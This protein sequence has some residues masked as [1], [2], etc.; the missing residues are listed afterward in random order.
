M[1]D[2][3]KNA[4]TSPPVLDYPRGS[5]KFI[6]TTDASDIGLGAILSTTRGTVIEYASRTLN[7]AERNYTTTEKECLAIVWVIRKLRHNLIGARFTLETDHKP[8]EWLES[9]RTSRA[10]SQRL[11]RWALE[12]RAYD[13]DVVHKPGKSNL[14][15][16]ALSRNPLSMV[17][18]R[19]PM[20]TS[21]IAR[22]QR[23]DPVLSTVRKQLENTNHQ[24][25]MSG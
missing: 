19:P 5:D 2:Q 3:L 7:A 15:A 1:F 21:D 16:D 23:D 12:L 10:H 6:L 18:L 11:E 24:A 20:E 25:P 17:A 9:S 4:L 13:F 14:N 22:A 8:L